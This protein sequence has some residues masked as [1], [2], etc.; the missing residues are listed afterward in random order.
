MEKK[1]GEKETQI[2]LSGGGE[3]FFEGALVV[4]VAMVWQIK[5]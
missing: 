5:F 2:V 3:G 4:A 1:R